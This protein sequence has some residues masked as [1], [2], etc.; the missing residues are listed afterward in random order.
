MRRALSG[1]LVAALLAASAAGIGCGVAIA[2]STVP[3]GNARAIAFYMRSQAAM[4]RYEG[5]SFTGTGTSYALVPKSGFDSFEFDFG[6]TPPG[7]HS[8]VDH[9]LVVQTNDGKITEEIDTMSAPGLPKLRL[10]QTSAIEIGEVAAKHPCVEL[11]PKNTASFVTLEEPFV[12]YGGYHF[13]TLVSPAP[14]LRLV[15]ATFNLAGGVAHEKDLVSGT[16]HLWQHS[17]LIVKGGPYN[18]NYLT[19]S[20]FRYMRVARLQSPPALGKCG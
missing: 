10:W 4:K 15:H 20:D 13:A 9:V 17:H 19:E 14:G 16:S 2:A 8:A 3:T 5:I 11:I 12:I 1:K 7:Y 18:N 6:A